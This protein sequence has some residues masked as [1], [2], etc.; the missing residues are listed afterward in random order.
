MKLHPSLSLGLAIGGTLLVASAAAATEITLSSG[1]VRYT[2]ETDLRL[3]VD[4]FN[5]EGGAA[6]ATEVKFIDANGTVVQTT[7]VTATPQ[8]AN[9]ADYT[10]PDPGGSTASMRVDVIYT[11]SADCKPL[12]PILEVNPGDVAA[13]R[14]EVSVTRGSRTR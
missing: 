8:T 5:R 3:N 14:Y 10:A 6:C 4:N 2:E 12:R 11:A 1:Y 9:T 13:N 7:P